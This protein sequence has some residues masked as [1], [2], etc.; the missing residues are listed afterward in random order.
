MTASL[1]NLL[2]L[3]RG[4]SHLMPSSLV[5]VLQC[6][7]KAYSNFVAQISGIYTVVAF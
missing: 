5:L 6:H 4:G 2:L 7:N 1:V 3:T